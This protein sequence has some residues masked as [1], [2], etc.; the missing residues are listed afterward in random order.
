MDLEKISDDTLF[1]VITESGDINW[2]F[3]ALKVIISRLKLKLHLTNNEEAVRE[4]CGEIRALLKKSM[5]IPN[6]KKDI[7]IIMERFG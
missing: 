4:S 5:N 3:Y 2:S 6:A 7:Q 1:R